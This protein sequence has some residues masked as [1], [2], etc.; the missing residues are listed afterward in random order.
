MST[1][2]KNILTTVGIGIVVSVVANL[3]VRALMK[4]K[5]VFG[6]FSLDGALAFGGDSTQNEDNI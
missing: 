2:T 1:E 6:W 5:K 3:L 4:N